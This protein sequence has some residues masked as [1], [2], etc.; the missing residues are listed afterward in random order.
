MR[1]LESELLPMLRE[2]KEIQDR[3]TDRQLR[4][5]QGEPG[6][7]ALLL[8]V[9]N[10][11]GLRPFPVYDQEEIHH[12]PEKMFIS[13]LAGAVGTAFAD[14]DA[15]PSVRANVGC[16]C[17][18]TLLGGVKQTFFPDKMPWL[19]EHLA[20]DKLAEITEDDLRESDEF[21]AGLE[22]MRNMKQLLDGTGIEVYPM[23][24]QGP[25]DMAHLWLGNEFFYEV[26]DDPEIVHHALRLAVACIDYAFRKNLEIIAPTDHVCHYNGLVLP[27]SAPL[28]LSEDTSTLLCREHLE[29]YMIPYTTELLRRF[30]GGYIHYCGSN[31]HL[32]AITEELE[33]SIGLNFG[34]PERHCFAKILPALAAHGKS[35]VMG[36]CTDER[37][38]AAAQPDGSFNIFFTVACD[39][40]EQ[41]RVLEHH[42]EQI[43]QAGRK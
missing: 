31:P 28:K 27:A 24:I 25:V 15:V 37:I 29:A 14:G 8:S 16:G 5:W 11:P 42:A 18:N 23:D 41:T 22:V 13:Q 3:K 21:K 1:Y 4:Q 33:G 43:L 17:I 38:A 34:N 30:G 40:A 6:L 19:L 2:R 7:C 9:R 10:I 35:Y 39:Y 36:D 32:L 12:D 26:Y 20:P